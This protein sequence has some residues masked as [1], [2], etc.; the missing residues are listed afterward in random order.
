LGEEL[1]PLTCTA[2]Q[3]HTVVSGKN[4]TWLRLC[5]ANPKITVDHL[6]TLLRNPRITPE[7]PQLIS[8]NDEWMSSYKLQVAIVNCPK[9]PF[10]LA[11]RI[12]QMLFWKD[13]VKI[14]D[15]YRLLPKIRRS[16]E[17]QL[18]DKVQELTLGEKI[19]LARTAPRAIIGYLRWQT[20]P[21]V[22]R[23]LLR[24]N[25]LV[26]DDILVIINEETTPD[27]ILEAIGSD[28]KWS[29]QYPIRVALV[30]NR[31]T[32]LR[33]SLKFLSRLQKPELKAIVNAPHTPELLKRAADRILSGEY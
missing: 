24:N 31:K 15:N 6:M 29:L 17:N 2:E 14:A 5:L 30:R 32:P 22:I 4:P 11:I 1:S 7:I 25:H 10:P 23:A 20:E 28:Y 27:F 18:R 8:R 21:E 19:S 12:L 9:T 33:I 13:L 26:E 3:L 16:A